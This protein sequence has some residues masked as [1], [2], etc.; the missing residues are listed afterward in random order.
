MPVKE[1]LLRTTRKKS[2]RTSILNTV[3][4]HS[5]KKDVPFITEDIIPAGTYQIIISD[6]ID[7]ETEKGKAAVDLVYIFT[8]EDGFSAHAKERYVSNGYRW[9][10]LI[11][12]LFDV[13]LLTE[14]STGAQLKGIEELVTVSYAREGAL[15]TLQNRRPCSKKLPKPPAKVI[16]TEEDV[17][18]D[19]PEFDDFLEEDED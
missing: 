1:S 14:D 17:D 4:H 7:T 18:D 11:D 15:G 5:A 10:Q 16:D 13:G 3:L 8:S 9:E 12:H 6:V 19:D 2:A